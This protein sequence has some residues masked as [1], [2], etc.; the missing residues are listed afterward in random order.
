MASN[1]TVI[2]VGNLTDDPQ[3]RYTAQG[4][5]V[6]RFNVAVNR[7]WQDRNSG[8]WREETSFFPCTVWRDQAENVAHTLKKGMRVIVSGRLQQR[9]W[10][11]A[12]GEQRTTLEIVVDEC[13]PSLRWAQAEVIKAARGV[14]GQFGAASP[15][16]DV[17]DQPP[18]EPVSAGL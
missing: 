14:S 16:E 10:E 13:G 4:Q 1:N 9:N 5:P 11:T 17:A 18:D 2:V 6:T 12:E 15:D 8:E 3:M 7:R